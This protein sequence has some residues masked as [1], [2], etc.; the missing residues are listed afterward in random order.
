MASSQGARC[1]LRPPSPVAA[2]LS[3][4]L[5]AWTR[6]PC[7]FGNSLVLPPLWPPAPALSSHPGMLSRPPYLKHIRDP[8]VL[9]SQVLLYF[10]LCFLT[11]LQTSVYCLLVNCIS[12][13]MGHKFH[14]GGRFISHVLCTALVAGQILRDF[15]FWIMNKWMN[16]LE[17]STR[18]LS[19]YKWKSET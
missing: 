16:G 3:L 14:K 11:A 18:E 7:C 15:L 5:W 12:P 8:T 4:S 19:F 9:C 6:L 17:N 1:T 10:P 13:Q 2:T